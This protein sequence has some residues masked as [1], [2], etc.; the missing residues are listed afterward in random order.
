L[1][2]GWERAGNTLELIGIGDDFLNRTSMVQKLREMI[3][4]WEYMKLKSF[5]TTKEMA[6]RLKRHPTEWERIFVNYTSDK[7]EYAEISKN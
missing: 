2:L 3:I 6:T 1:K 4:K 5:Y 7:S